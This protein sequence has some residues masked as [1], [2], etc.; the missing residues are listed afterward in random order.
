MKILKS[1]ISIIIIVAII[2]IVSIVGIINA[3]YDGPKKIKTAQKL[4]SI[5][6]N[7]DDFFGPMK[8]MLYC[9]IAAPWIDTDIFYDYGYYGGKYDFYD[10]DIS[11]NTAINS[12]SSSNWFK[13]GSSKETASGN[14]DFSKTNIQVENVDEADVIKTDG[15]YIYSLS[16]NK[17]IITDARDPQNTKV[18]FELTSTSYSGTSPEEIL[19]YGNDLIVIGTMRGPMTTVEVYD[20]TSKENPIKKEAYCVNGR[21]YTSRLTDGKLYVLSTGQLDYD[22]GKVDNSYVE[23]S[24]TRF[25]SYNDIYYFNNKLT[26]A[27]TTISTLDLDKEK[28]KVDVSMYLLA[29]DNI[30]VSQDNMYLV[31]DNYYNQKISFLPAFIRL[32]GPKGIIGEAKDLYTEDDYFYDDDETTI[33]KFALNNGKIK[34]VGKAK[35]EGYTIDQFSLDEYNS[36]LRVAL[37]TDKGSRVAIFNDK[38]KKIGETEKVAR[39]ERMYSSRF[40]GDRGYLVT[41]L[42]TDPLFCIDLSDPKNPEILGELQ[43]SGYSTY[44]HPYDETHLIGIGYESEVKTNR[45][46]EGKVTSQYAVITGMKMAL[47]DV[48][49]INNPIKIS[50]TQIGDKYTRSAILTNH[51]AL[52]FSKEKGIIAIP[53]NTYEKELEISSTNGDLSSLESSY[54]TNSK[55]YRTEGYLVYGI[56]L[57]DGFVPKGFIDHSETDPKSYSGTNLI[58]GVYIKDYLF[59]VS[60][61]MVKVNKLDTLEQVASVLI[62]GVE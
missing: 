61:G 14:N 58:R 57:E 37:Y 33:Y 40:I 2:V 21:Y 49:N 30:Y 1:K 32:L 22:D 13:S 46:S 36:N 56:N 35:E 52:L 25:I 12:T 39:G 31:A 26:T 43:I 54:T 24:V 5:Y 7:E 45:N 10:S 51:K 17:V 8:K 55:E 6:G 20:I 15:E 16:D 23:N 38:M 50:D 4:E 28:A 48:S 11:F 62:K 19:L 44:L 41:Y 27:Q 18:V 42:N 59:T 53:V 34:Y 9:I 47:F 3:R 29:L 60:Q